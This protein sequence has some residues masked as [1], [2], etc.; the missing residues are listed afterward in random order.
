MKTNLP[1][2]AAVLCLIVSLN[3][4]TSSKNAIAPEKNGATAQKAEAACFVQMNNGT[5]KNYATLTL[6]TGVF[7]TPHLLA[8]G[9]VIISANE[10]AAYQNK[11]HYAV[12]Q[13]GFTTDKPSN[14][15]VNALP[16]FA[17]RVASGKLNVYAVK[18]YNGHNT[19]E[20]FFLQIGDDG[21]IVPYKYELMSDLVKDNIEAYNFFNRKKKALAFNKRLLVTAGMYNNSSFISKN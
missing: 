5:V 21:A 1:N 7:K 20:K 13:Q 19:T 10:I 3:A 6:V 16:G 12:A 15:A 8:D 18:Y 2:F 11:E 9:K 17:V 4:C 14:V